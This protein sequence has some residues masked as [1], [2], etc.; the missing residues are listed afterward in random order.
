MSRVR[1]AAQITGRG[2]PQNG[3][4]HDFYVHGMK[5]HEWGA[6]GSVF[7]NFCNVLPRGVIVLG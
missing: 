4:S 3:Y 2:N 6:W 5:L 7:R 1:G